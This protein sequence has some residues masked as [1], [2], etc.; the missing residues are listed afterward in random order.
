[1][2]VEIRCDFLGSKRR[3]DG[4]LKDQEFEV[5]REQLEKHSTANGIHTAKKNEEVMTLQAK[6][7]SLQDEISSLN[8]STSKTYFL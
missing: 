8:V 5:L 1:M 4:S 7:N 3:A 2:P 6:I